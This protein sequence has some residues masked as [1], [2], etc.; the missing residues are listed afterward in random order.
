MQPMNH[1][2]SLHF[3]CGKAGAGKSTLSK[4]LALQHDAALICE[5]I[6]LARLY[7]D[8]LHGFDDY[9]RCARRI[10]AVVAPMVVDLL[11]RQSV[12]LDFP[13]NTV[14]SRAWFRSIFEQA[15]V[16]HTLHH[17]E[18]SNAV[19]LG[20]IARRNVER[21]EGSHALDEQTFM[22]ITSFFEAPAPSE[23]FNVVVHR[24]GE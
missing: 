6:W 3:M 2:P 9:I 21:P 7:P 23:G 5:D 12:V 18:A 24:Q 19:C 10:K 15:G 20:R 17:L 11:R 16:A 14:Q 8:E 1:P 22:H 13:A 4:A